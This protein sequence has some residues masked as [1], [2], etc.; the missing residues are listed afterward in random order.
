MQKTPQEFYSDL[1]EKFPFE[2]TSLQDLLLS[3][4]SEFVF[5]KNNK[6]LFVIKGYAGTGK[7]TTISTLVNNLWR[8]GTKAV[9][10]APTG[11]AAK[12]IANY[13]GRNAFTIHKNIYF[14]KKNKGGGVDFVLKPNKNSNTIF[15]VDEASMI[16]DSPTSAKLFEKGSLLDDLISYVY[17]GIGC[18]LV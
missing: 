4:L 11:R 14:P 16:P 5:E 18:K 1:V 9:L 12:V 17:A 2:P 15:F 3:K 8:T 6:S 10:L 7:T 13:S